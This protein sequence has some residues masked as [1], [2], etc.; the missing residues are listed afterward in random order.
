MA[1]VRT[2]CF[3][4]LASYPKISPNLLFVACDKHHD[5]KQ[6]GKKGLISTYSS[7]STVNEFEAGTKAGTWRQELK[8]ESGG[9]NLCRDRNGMLLTDLLIVA[10]SAFFLIL[11]KTTFPVVATPTGRMDPSISIINL[12]KST[13]QTCLQA[14]EWRQSLS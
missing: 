12:K 5:Q 1:R 4:F 14:I 9:R 7:Q 10:C 13:S 3:L 6:R 2:G 11:P 8:Q